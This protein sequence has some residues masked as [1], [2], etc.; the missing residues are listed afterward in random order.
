MHCNWHWLG[1]NNI[2]VRL[3]HLLKQSKDS[4]A[5]LGVLRLDQKDLSVALVV[6]PQL[7][8]YKTD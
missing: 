1:L 7:K 6:S 4:V 2:N 5:G 8:V 3:K